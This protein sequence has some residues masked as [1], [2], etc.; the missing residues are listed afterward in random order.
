MT[1]DGTVDLHAAAYDPEML[2]A[3]QVS[4]G[5][6]CIDELST[7]A[8]VKVQWDDYGNIWGAKGTPHT[9]LCAHLDSV[10]GTPGHDDWAGVL[11]I[12]HAARTCNDMAWLLTVDEEIGQRGAQL[13]KPDLSGI[14]RCVLFDRHGDSDC[15]YY[16][17]SCTYSSRP[18]ADRLCA[19]LSVHGL[20]Y[21][22]CEGGLS[23]ARVLKNALP[24]VNLSV[25]FD[26]EHTADATI[27]LNALKKA[28]HAAE[29]L[30][31]GRR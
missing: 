30:S 23:D 13:A 12:L 16:S 10:P 22:P 2:Y 21:V 5:Y 7:L 31:T 15:V 11:V 4:R 3:S 19:E 20:Q 9:L 25:G 26:N 14:E 28:M 18:H 29:I 27:D 8:G 1:T 17:G 6:R 24:T